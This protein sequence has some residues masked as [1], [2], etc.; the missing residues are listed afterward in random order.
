MTSR[1]YQAPSHQDNGGWEKGFGHDSNLYRVSNRTA[2]RQ[3]MRV[4]NTS[5]VRVKRE[6]KGFG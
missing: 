2:K 1:S 5:K 4:Q 6:Q 3:A